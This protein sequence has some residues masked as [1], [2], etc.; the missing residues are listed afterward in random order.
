M[1]LIVGWQD[2]S[3]ALLSL[4]VCTSTIQQ[5]SERTAHS[6]CHYLAASHALVDNMREMTEVMRNRILATPLIH[7]SL[8]VDIFFIIGGTLLA[9]TWLQRAKRDAGETISGALSICDPEP[10]SEFCFVCEKGFTSVRGSLIN[11][12]LSV[13][14]RSLNNHKH[15]RGPGSY[16]RVVVIAPGTWMLHASLNFL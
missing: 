16:T 13:T 5:F 14:S 8:S 11:F 6:F 2:T 9:F 3:S 1:W 15:I 4:T 12:G 10:V 7:F